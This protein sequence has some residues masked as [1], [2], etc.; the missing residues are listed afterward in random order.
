[1]QNIAIPVLAYVLKGIKA[2]M[3]PLITPP[4]MALSV[5]HFA[6]TQRSLLASSQMRHVPVKSQQ[7]PE[8]KR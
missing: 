6:L 1:M 7:V 3:N 4:L 5:A 2:A 8:K